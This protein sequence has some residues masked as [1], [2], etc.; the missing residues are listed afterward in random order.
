MR[1]IVYK[2]DNVNYQYHKFAGY[3]LFPFRLSLLITSTLST[4]LLLYVL[5]W[6][7]QSLID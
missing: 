2:M 5:D 4:S 3:V 6:I 1:I 7:Q